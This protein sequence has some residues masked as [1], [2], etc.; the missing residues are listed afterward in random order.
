MSLH[1]SVYL[2]YIQQASR[3]FCISCISP[4]YSRLPMVSVTFSEGLDTNYDRLSNVLCFHCVTSC[5]WKTMFHACFYVKTGQ[6]S[7]T[8]SFCQLFGKII[9]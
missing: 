4:V 6:I 8:L 3:G 7:N 5:P 1:V 2:L 9:N